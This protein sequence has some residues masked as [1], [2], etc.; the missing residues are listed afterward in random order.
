M[1]FTNKHDHGQ[2]NKTKQQVNNEKEKQQITHSDCT[3]KDEDKPLN[4]AYIEKLKMFAT[5]PR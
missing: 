1:I 5:V 2:A 3:M 4:M